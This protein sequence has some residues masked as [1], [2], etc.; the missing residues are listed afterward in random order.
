MNLRAP[1]VAALVSLLASAPPARTAGSPT[2]QGSAC[3]AEAL[4]CEDFEDTDFAAR[5]WYDGP[6]GDLSAEEHAPGSAHSW[7]CVYPEGGRVCE[8]GTP[9]RHLFTPTDSVYL[10]YWV[11]YGARFVGSGHPYHPHEFLF[12]TNKDGE[13]VGPAGTHLTTYVEQLAGVPR[14]ALQDLLNVDTRCIL[15]NDDSFVGCNGDLATFQFTEDRSVASCNGLQGDL[16]K[17][18]CFPTDATHWYSARVWDAPPANN[19]YDA[20]WHRV[21]ALFRLNSVAGGKGVVDGAMR[22]WL[23]GRLVLSYD[24]ILYRTAANSDMLFN[25]LL[26]AP[27]IGDG[28]PVRQTM[29]VDDLRVLRTGDGGGE[30]AARRRAWVPFASRR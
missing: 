13:Y 14:L 10:E 28:S 30:P 6:R 18:D 21:A 16:D 12:L 23:D 19:L 11:K 22:Y 9:A 25:Q 27:Y 5:G 1:A 8:G 2:A 15:R 26:V 29:W 3:P 7:Q 4:L 17:R 20:R 24:H